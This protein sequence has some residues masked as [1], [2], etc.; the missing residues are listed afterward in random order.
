MEGKYIYLKGK[1]T[2][3]GFYE[4]DLYEVIYLKNLFLFVLGKF[5]RYAVVGEHVSQGLGLRDFKSPPYTQ[6]CFLS[7]CLMP[8]Y[9]G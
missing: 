3:G 9:S 8:E 2:C 1:S 4:N 7:S 6:S 5:R